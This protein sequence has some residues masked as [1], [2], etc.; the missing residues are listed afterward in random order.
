MPVLERMSNRQQHLRFLLTINRF[1]LHRSLVQIGDGQIQKCTQLTWND[2]YLFCHCCE[3]VKHVQEKIAQTNFVFNPWLNVNN[4][5]SV[6][7]TT[8]KF[9]YALMISDLKY[10]D[11]S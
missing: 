9:I 6:D 2:L 7:Y 11:S 10:S 3:S 4:N 5:C 1:R 8:I